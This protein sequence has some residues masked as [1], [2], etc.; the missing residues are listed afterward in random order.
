MSQTKTQWILLVFIQKQKVFNLILLG[1]RQGNDI[2]G[3]CAFLLLVLLNHGYMCNNL[4]YLLTSRYIFV[5]SKPDVWNQNKVSFYHREVT[6]H[7]YIHNLP[8][9]IY[10][11]LK[12]IQQ[13][14][15]LVVVISDVQILK[16][17][18]FQFALSI[19]DQPS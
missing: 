5:L 8:S 9:L 18:I 15:K 13:Q 12:K 17:W 7:S 10:F 14:Q 3:Y 2:V 16:I 6:I 4:V 19:L 11:L 1:L